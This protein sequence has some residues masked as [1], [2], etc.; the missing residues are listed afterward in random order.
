MVPYARGEATRAELVG[1]A[2][3]LFAER[4]YEGTSIEAVLR[5]TGLSRGALYHHFASK[6][7]LFEAVFNKVEDDVGQ[8]VATA[9]AGA[10]S[11]A[12]ALLAGCLEWARLAG[13]PVVQRIVLVDAP[14]VLGWEKW[15]ALEEDHAL[16]TI[17][18]A[19]AAVAEEGGL[20]AGLVDV[21]SHVLLAGVNEIALWIARSDDPVTAAADGERAVD[22]LV[23]RLIVI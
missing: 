14:A 8:Q 21:F 4:G 6:E 7:E 12:T 10:T 3:D 17:R 15:R 1:A 20:D 11:A 2:A 19:L 23:R 13:S 22:E 18:L 5:A 16:G 9:W